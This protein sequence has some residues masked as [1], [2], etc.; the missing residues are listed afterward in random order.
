VAAPLQFVVPDFDLGDEPFAAD[1]QVGQRYV[2]LLGLWAS[3]VHWGDQPAGI[4]S[5]SEPAHE[6]MFVG[7]IGERHA[8]WREFKFD[9]LQSEADLAIVWPSDSSSWRS[10]D[11][12]SVALG[13]T[14]NRHAEAH[15][16]R[17]VAVTGTAVLLGYYSAPPPGG[18]PAN[19]LSPNACVVQVTS[20]RRSAEGLL[21]ARVTP[22][23]C[24]PRRRR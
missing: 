24:Q 3:R 5:A 10:P 15:P 6:K 11:L 7:T 23:D 14:D 16:G 2:A 22:L 19:V 4:P 13:N 1:V 21:L 20:L 18:Q 17:A 12:R 8:S 9:V